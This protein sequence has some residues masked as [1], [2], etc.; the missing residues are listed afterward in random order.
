VSPHDS[1]GANLV[2]QVKA[3]RVMRVLPL[4]NEEVNECWIAD[5]DRFSY[6]ALNGSDRLTEPMI[7]QGGQ[8][9]STD[10][11]TALEYVSRGLTQIS[12]DHGAAS[13]GALG[14]A[15]ST[16]EELHLLAKLVRALGSE[17]IDYRT[18]HADFSAE[19]S[20]VRWL[21][22]SIASLSTLQSV[23]VVGSFLR[24]DHPLFAQRIRQAA[25]KGAQVHGLTG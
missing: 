2:V 11:P 3:N 23:L 17:N 14:S 25:R 12:V 18:R 19:A 20:G 24:K 5:R 13:I 10:W 4:E 7:K 15:H 22:T 1:T 9:K 16:V 6:E 8:W 21:G